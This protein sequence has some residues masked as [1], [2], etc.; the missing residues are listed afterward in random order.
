LPD[1]LLQLTMIIEREKGIE[2]VLRWFCKRK[3][4]RG[5]GWV[6]GFANLVSKTGPINRRG[7]GSISHTLAKVIHS[8][9][10]PMVGC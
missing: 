7:H 5:F 6:P 4:W 2:L 8:G 10:H 1:N 3:G 9:I